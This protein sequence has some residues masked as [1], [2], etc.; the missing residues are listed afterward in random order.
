MLY[1]KFDIKD[2]EKYI[3]FKKIYD[4]LYE[5]KPKEES[6]PIEFWQE[7]IPPYAKL[8]LQGFYKEENILSPLIHES[9]KSF[10]NYLEFGLEADFID[11]TAINSTKS[12]VRF[13]ALGYPYGGMDKLM[14]FLKA[15]DCIPYE[16]FNG[17]SVCSLSWNT[18]YEYSAIE[19]PEKTKAYLKR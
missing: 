18:T 17:F 12:Q 2:Q 14:I 19:L 10:I 15:F 13:V 6:K 9:F 4:V 1:I 8:F 11:V 3:I 16:I 7:I 5:I